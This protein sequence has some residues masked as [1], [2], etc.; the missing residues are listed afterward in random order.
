MM[1]II[2]IFNI[3]ESES[4]DMHDETKKLSSRKFLLGGIIILLIVA[5][6]FSAGAVYAFDRIEKLFY[7]KPYQNEVDEAAVKFG[8]EP[9]LLSL[10]DCTANRELHPAL[11][12]VIKFTFIFYPISAHMSIE[13]LN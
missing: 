7:P 5:M 13:Y 8:I 6:A 1:G 9:N 11:K 2:F 12:F 4:C 10:A 3:I